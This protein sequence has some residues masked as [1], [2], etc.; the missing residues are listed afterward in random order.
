MGS[1]ISRYD[2]ETT[3][4]A[5]ISISGVTNANRMALRP[6]LSD[7]QTFTVSPMRYLL[8]SDVCISISFSLLSDDEHIDFAWHDA[9]AEDCTMRTLMCSLSIDSIKPLWL[10]LPFIAK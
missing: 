10:I 8:L 1:L 3:M 9:H 7:A 4:H 6:M 2:T 5:T